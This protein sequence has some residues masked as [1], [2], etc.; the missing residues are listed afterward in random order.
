M[1]TRVLHTIPPVCDVCARTLIL[2]SFP[3]VQSRAGA[4][5]YH[6]PR[7]RF[8]QVLAA[9][10]RCDAPVSI[11]EK[12]SFLLA[13]HIALWDV[14]ASCE[15]RSS[16]DS[17]IQ[18]VTPN[19]LSRIFDAAD[20]RRIFTNGNTAYNLYMRYCYPQFGRDAV[21]LPSTSPANAN[22]SLEKLVDCWKIIKE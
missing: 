16:A 2:G 14:A 7:N 15:I 18:N 13:R 5:F 20:I 9:V 10:Y 21:K 12:R 11:D 22:F 1:S 6:H 8:W 17:S 4:F 19:D 3:S